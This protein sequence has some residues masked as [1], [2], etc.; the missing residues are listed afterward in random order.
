MSRRVADKPDTK[1]CLSI[2]HSQLG[3]FSFNPKAIW[4]G[5]ALTNA[6]S[7]ERMYNACH[8]YQSPLFMN[9]ILG[10][11]PAKHIKFNEPDYCT[12]LQ[13]SVP[14]IQCRPLPESNAI[15]KPSFLEDDKEMMVGSGGELVMC[16]S[17]T[18]VSVIEAKESYVSASQLILACLLYTSPSPRD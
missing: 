12:V 5:C 1:I 4:T 6:V 11:Q 7:Y 14:T 16:E 15:L 3:K 10:Y 17:P 8:N 2:H 9:Y 13:S 18:E